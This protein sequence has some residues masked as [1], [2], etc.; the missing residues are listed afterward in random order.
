MSRVSNAL[1]MLM[2]IRGKGRIKT[3][4]LARLLE[5]KPRMIQNY[6]DDLEMCGI[7]IDSHPGKY[8]GYSISTAYDYL[9]KLKV[10]E[11]EMRSFE[12]GLNQ[13]TTSGFVFVQEFERLFNKVKISYTHSN[14][15]V[16]NF[17]DVYGSKVQAV[18]RD[19]NMEKT[20]FVSIQS[21]IL[22]HQKI[23]IQY[24]ALSSKTIEERVI[25]PYAVYEYRGSLYTTG[26][27]E[28]RQE[29][30][31]FKLSRIQKL[32]LSEGQFSVDQT[33]SLKTYMQNCLG[34]FKDSSIQVKL[35]IKH[36]MSVI[37]SEKIWADNQKISFSKEG[38][39]IIFEAT[40]RGRVELIGWILSMGRSC[41]V[42][43]PEELR[44]AVSKEIKEI[45][46]NY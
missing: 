34:I 30:R 21:A 19:P 36:P 41:V 33:F 3:E 10:S 9:L 8:G 31:D 2:L 28:L 17:G 14:Q 45:L 1:K 4:E 37:V 18:D 38:D 24:N 35:L 26:F 6:K 46:D 7:H 15:S 25:H 22:A 39:S 5:V 16:E 13:L 11:D 44:E 20:Y 43:E 40:M 42:L 23:V 32:T 12:M 27:C 29:I